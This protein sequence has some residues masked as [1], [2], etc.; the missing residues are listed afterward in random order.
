MGLYVWMMLLLILNGRKMW[1]RHHN[2]KELSQDLVA[3]YCYVMQ[4]FIAVSWN[5]L[6]F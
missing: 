5:S 1:G 6:S 2:F 4:K 3:T